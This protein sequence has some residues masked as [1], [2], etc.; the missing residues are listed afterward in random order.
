MAKRKRE[1][2]D[3]KIDRIPYWSGE[4]IKKGGSSRTSVNHSNRA[5][6]TGE[7]FINMVL[8]RETMEFA[9][10]THPATDIDFWHHS[11]KRQESVFGDRRSRVPVQ[12]KNE[13]IIINDNSEHAEEDTLQNVLEAHLAFVKINIYPIVRTRKKS[14]KQT[15]AGDDVVV[16]TGR[17][18]KSLDQPKRVSV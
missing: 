5:H 9:D 1:V 15:H 13:N 4:G 16:S 2:T 6:G 10:F 18:G 8:V 7:Q 14:V 11:K 3:V 17:G 12:S